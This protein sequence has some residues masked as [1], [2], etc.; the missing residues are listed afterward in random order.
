M[1]AEVALPSNSDSNSVEIEVDAVGEVV[2][3]NGGKKGVLTTTV[4]DVSFDGMSYL[5]TAFI[6]ITTTIGHIKAGL[7]AIG[8]RGAILQSAA[9][10]VTLV[11]S[12]VEGGTGLD[13]KSNT[14]T[15]LVC[16]Y[17]Y[18]WI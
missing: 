13:V 9:G 3:N 7:L 12:K 14:A 15:V 8:Q 1:D 18:V 2:V 11:D 5:S 10:D 16:V 17:S 6:N 4:D